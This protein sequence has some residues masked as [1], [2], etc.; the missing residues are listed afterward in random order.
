MH[1]CP[2]SALSL[3]TLQICWKASDKLEQGSNTAVRQMGMKVL[4]S[5]CSVEAQHTELWIDTAWLLRSVVASA[6]WVTHNTMA[7]ST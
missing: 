1:M 5:S 3:P 2:F 7:T 4:T 6:G